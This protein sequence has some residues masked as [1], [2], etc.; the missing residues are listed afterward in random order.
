MSAIDELIAEL[1]ASGMPQEGAASTFHLLQ[2]AP[3]R[4]SPGL[5]MV[6]VSE[7]VRPCEEGGNLTEDSLRICRDPRRDRRC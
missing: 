2:Q 6:A 7:R 1:A 3:E 4:R 5:G